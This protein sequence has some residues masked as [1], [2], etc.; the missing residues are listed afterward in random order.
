[1]RNHCGN[2]INTSQRDRHE[3]SRDTKLRHTHCHN[4]SMKPVDSSA[5]EASNNHTKKTRDLCVDQAGSF[6]ATIQKPPPLK[7]HNTLVLTIGFQ[8]GRAD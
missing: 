5:L 8:Q 2:H 4:S 1:M 6:K 3:A 7:G